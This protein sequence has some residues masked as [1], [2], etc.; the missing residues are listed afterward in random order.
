[1][2]QFVVIFAAGLVLGA[3]AHAG[4]SASPKNSTPYNE[5]KV[6]TIMSQF[7]DKLNKLE[8]AGLTDTGELAKQVEVQSGI[9]DLITKYRN[10]EFAKY[11][12]F[13]SLAGVLFAAILGGLAPKLMGKRSSE[14][15]P[16]P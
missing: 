15:K 16:N 2:V 13:T 4:L 9:L 5:E 11:A 7:Q 8:S 10:A 14:A 12:P 1:M 6:Q 3:L